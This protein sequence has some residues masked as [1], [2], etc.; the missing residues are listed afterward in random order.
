MGLLLVLALVAAYANRNIIIEQ[1][2]SSGSV[3]AEL[4]AQAADSAV[5]WA[6]AMLN[7]GAID[8]RCM[9]T[10]DISLGD[11]RSRYLLRNT[12]TNGYNYATQPLRSTRDAYFAGCRLIPSD[13][14]SCICPNTGHLGLTPAAGNENSAAFRITYD[15]PQ[16]SSAETRPGT[17]TLVVRGCANAGTI[18]NGCLSTEHH[19]VTDAIVDVRAH[20]GLTKALPAPPFATVTVGQ[21]ITADSSASLHL[22]NSDPTTALV[23]QAGGTLRNAS[24][25]M[26]SVAGPG[27]SMNSTENL[28][29]QN[30]TALARQFSYNPSGSD[31]EN[32]NC[33]FRRFFA[34]DQALYKRQPAIVRLSCSGGCGLSDLTAAHW[35]GQN[36]GRPI[37]IDGDLTLNGSP[38]GA[39]GTTTKPMLLVVSGTLTISDAMDLVGLVYAHNVNWSASTGSIRGAVVAARNLTVSGGMTASYDPAILKLMRDT[40]GSFVRIPAAWTRGG[41]DQ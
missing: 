11:F 21:D 28:V 19:P 34:M 37:Y 9:P 29:T 32:N 8:T 36:A 1:R 22:I 15:A 6:A 7:G 39:V 18:T 24:G 38:T 33:F 31:C 20:L 35:T 17:V 10:S 12:E 14:P 3:R 25:S 23:I 27:G 16:S 41:T 40:Y 13:E 30:S 26:L 5:D 2:I 4:A